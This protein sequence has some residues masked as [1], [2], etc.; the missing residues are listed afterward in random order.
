MYRVTKQALPIYTYCITVWAQP[1]QTV[2][3]RPFRSGTVTTMENAILT[4]WNELALQTN[5]LLTKWLENRQLL[6]SCTPIHFNSNMHK[7]LMP[8][9]MPWSF[10][11]L[12]VSWCCRRQAISIFCLRQC[13][14]VQTHSNLLLYAY[15]KDY[16]CEAIG[17]TVRLSIIFSL[18]KTHSSQNSFFLTKSVLKT[19]FLWCNTWIWIIH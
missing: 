19:T 8:W 1:G 12:N 14:Q 18:K 6:R 2:N 11:I 15:L 4:G 17:K 10:I 5:E 9:I 3:I 16:H 7:V 13:D